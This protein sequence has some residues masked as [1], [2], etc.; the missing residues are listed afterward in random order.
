MPLVPVKPARALWVADRALGLPPSAPPSRDGP[1]VQPQ[2]MERR[3]I[4]ATLP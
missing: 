3:S 1:A 2:G 4:Q